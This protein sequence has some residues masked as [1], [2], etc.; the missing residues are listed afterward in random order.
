MA[1]VP[2]LFTAVTS[3][4]G[5]QLD[6]DFLACAN[7]AGDPAQVFSVALG[8][9]AAH[10]ARVDQISLISTVAPATSPDIFAA[11]GATI[12]LS[13]SPVT[14]TSFANCTTAQVGSVKRLIP[15]ADASIAASANL[16]VD[17]ATSGTFVMPGNARME[18][19]ATSTNTFTV[20]TIYASGTWTPNQGGGL[21]VVGAFSSSGTWS[22]TGRS[23]T[24]NQQ[25]NGATS[26]S[27]TA[28]GTV[29]TN[30]PFVVMPNAVCSASNGNANVGGQGFI[31]AGTQQVTSVNT[32]AAS[33]SI[34]ISGSV[35][36]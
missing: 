36:V 20:I 33:P 26:V 24:F 8:T 2:N 19:L 29:S 32:F 18:V 10:A 6:V 27:V 9:A 5:A 23:L 16:V 13:G 3:A 14:I 34:I 31:S 21:T 12:N 11:S 35:I 30:F 4:T 17:G 28:G 1:T 15:A 25:V 7:L 22:K